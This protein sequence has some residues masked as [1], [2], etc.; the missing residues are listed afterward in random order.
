MF[1]DLQSDAKDKVVFLISHRLYHF[2][3]MQKVIFMDGGKTTVG[4]HTQLMETVPLYRQLYESQTV[5]KEGDLD[6]E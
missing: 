1:A 4:T 5:Q 3:Q 6:E 2:P